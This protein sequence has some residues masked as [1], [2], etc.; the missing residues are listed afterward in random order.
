MSDWFLG[1]IRIFPYQSIPNGWHPCDGSM[2]QIRANA[3]LYSLLGVQFGG[4]GTNTFAL[5]DLRGRAMLDTQ[6]GTYQQGKA[7]GTETV[8]LTTA[9]LP[10]HTHQ[11]AVSNTSGNYPV[12]GAGAM[13]AVG[14]EN[15][16]IPTT[17]QG[18]NAV[19]MNASTIGTAGAGAPHT[20]IQPS[21]GCT[22]CIA[23]NGIYPT[24][25]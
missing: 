7:G 15:T 23:L 19:T 4:D 2:L 24:R 14:T 25:P 13:L 1:E 5:P 17:T 18:L 10:L 12:P 8:A 21:L 16:Y 11:L 9:N 20:N 3:A 6:P 22:V